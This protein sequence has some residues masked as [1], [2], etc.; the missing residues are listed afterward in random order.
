MQGFGGQLDQGA[1]QA[2]FS[3]FAVQHF[4]IENFVLFLSGLEH[5]V[6]HVSAAFLLP[7]LL[8]SGA[9]ADE[10]DAERHKEDAENQDVFFCAHYQAT[11]MDSRNTLRVSLRS[12]RG[13]N[14]EKTSPLRS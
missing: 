9:Q 13:R 6:N 8:Q 7:D 10:K 14:Y 12:A 1:G 3:G 5:P 11:G 4:Q 2:V